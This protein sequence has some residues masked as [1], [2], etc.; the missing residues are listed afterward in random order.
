M[1]KITTEGR[2]NL[3]NA[4]ECRFGHGYL[5][6]IET[7]GKCR[8]HEYYRHKIYSA[9][10]IV[11]VVLNTVIIDTTFHLLKL[12]LPQDKISMSPYSVG[13]WQ[14]NLDIMNLDCN[15]YATLNYYCLNCILLDIVFNIYIQ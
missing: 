2:D 6:T 7:I 4:L 10:N 14:Q 13:C 11:S 3:S 9:S 5:E 15:R 1:Y 8:L 12:G